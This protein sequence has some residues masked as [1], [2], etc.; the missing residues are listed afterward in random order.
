MTSEPGNPRQWLRLF[1]ALCNETLDAAQRQQLEQLLL[2]RADARALYRRYLNLHLGLRFYD[3][4]GW[5][6]E[7]HAAQ[8]PAASAPIPQPAPSAS[9]PLLLP[10][11]RW[12]G[13]T[14]AYLSHPLHYSLLVATLTVVSLLL[15]SAQIRVP[16]GPPAQRLAPRVIPQPVVAQLVR[17]VEARWAEAEPVF[18]GLHLLQRRRLQLLAGLAEIRFRSGATVVLEGPANVQLLGE[19]QLALQ[20]GRLTAQV[21]PQASGFSVKTPTATVVDLG[22]EFGVQVDQNQATEVYVFE[23]IVAV[24]QAGP[25]EGAPATEGQ[26][27][28][29]PR[30]LAAGQSLRMERAEA[31]VSR[32]SVGSGDFVRRL[33]LPAAQAQVAEDVPL[34][35]LRDDPA[36][37]L[38][39]RAD[40][41][42]GLD[43]RGKPLPLAAHDAPLACWKDCGPQHNDLLTAP[44]AT[45]PDWISPRQARP[46]AVRFDGAY[47]AMVSQ[48]RV[49]LGSAHTIAAVVHLASTPRSFKTDSLFTYAEQSRG[50]SLVELGIYRAGD[51][52]RNVRMI[53]PDQDLYKG[54]RLGPNPPALHRRVLLVQIRN[55]RGEAAV[56]VNDQCQID[57]TPTSAFPTPAYLRI[58]QHRNAAQYLCGDLYELLILNRAL[59]QPQLRS[60]QQR[61]MTRYQIPKADEALDAPLVQP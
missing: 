15:T 14:V 10:P 55:Q 19:N 16:E 30:R 13:K 56:W 11:R 28:A 53:Y 51:P 23:G 18:E 61:L 47:H 29:S 8:P 41:V 48:R 60:L 1:G 40:A 9:V 6:T 46:A 59:S 44:K 12:W 50:Q 31:A 27:W 33:P 5:Q 34:L 20:V 21:A 22:T 17:T 58:G 7:P 2:S 25:E 26:D 42:N 4:H 32:G 45:H 39:L 38:W 24:H 54:G 36:L 35:D 57:R 43:G 37:L 52:R 49:Q 3:R